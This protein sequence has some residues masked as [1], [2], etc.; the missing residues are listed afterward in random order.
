MIVFLIVFD[1]VG[2]GSLLA[3]VHVGR[4]SNGSASGLELSGLYGL[5]VARGGDSSGK[6]W[7]SRRPRVQGQ[8]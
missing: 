1:G 6:G 8:G 4:V 2:M 5:A 3:R 7:T